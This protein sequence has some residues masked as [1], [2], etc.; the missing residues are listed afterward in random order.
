[1]KAHLEKKRVFLVGGPGG[2][3]KTTLAATLGIELARKGHRTV[4]LTV[5]PAKRLAQALGLQGFTKEL[6]EVTGDGLK[7]GMLFASMLDSERYFD[8]VMGRFAKSP[9]QLERILSNPLYRT[10]VENLGGTHEYAAMERLL[11]FAGMDRFEKIV[12]DT[13][14]TQNAV[15]LLSAPAR[16]ADFMDGSV[17]RWFR[18]SD[19]RYLQLFR[20]GTRLAMKLLQKIFGAEFLDAF[21]TFMDDLEGMHEGFRERNL[22]VIKLLQG[23]TSAFLL[24]NYPSEARHQES[25]V[26]LNSLKE[27]GIPLAAVLLN[28]ISPTPPHVVFPSMASPTLPAPEKRG[29]EEM[30]AYYE[31]LHRSQEH[32][33]EKF[34]TT[35]ATTPL[36]L[37]PQQA[38]PPSDVASLSQMGQFLVDLLEWKLRPQTEQRRPRGLPLQLKYAMCLTLVAGLTSLLMIFVMAWFIQRNYN[39]FMGDELGVSSQVIEVVR[40]EQKLLEGSLFILFL[41]SITVTF[42]ATF[43]VTRRLIGPIIAL[44]RQLLLY[45]QGDW[46]RDFRLRKDDEFRDL[47]PLVNKMRQNHLANFKSESGKYIRE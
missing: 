6:Q 12:V 43:Y 23:E 29:I 27:F 10:T 36:L 20:Q 45:C 38:T 5:D 7:E 25:L 39:L 26:F 13:P 3:G 35:L 1:M 15:E 42:T 31:A 28:R 9:E 2:V 21:S 18:G 14:P 11:E 32:W 22:E 44:Q 4:V 24:V 37:V 33:V 17:M 34:R 47:E 16:L 46:S 30:L 8:K 19:K 40:R 41:L